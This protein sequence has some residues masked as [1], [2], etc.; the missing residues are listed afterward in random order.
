M[1]SCHSMC[2][3]G[4]WSL[5]CLNSTVYVS[6][7]AVISHW[8]LEGDPGGMLV[9]GTPLNCCIYI[10]ATSG[11]GDRAVE[12]ATAGRMKLNCL[13]AEGD[14]GGR[15]LLISTHRIC[16]K[17]H[18]HTHTCTS[19]TQRLTRTHMHT[20]G[21]WTLYHLDS[22][23]NTGAYKSE[24]LDTLP[25]HTHRLTLRHVRGHMC[26]NTLCTQILSCTHV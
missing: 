21:T 25:K 8:L 5:W 9:R 11:E 1:P 3:L 26:R 16:P 10:I 4:G 23:S 12:T 7:C 13:R 18:I 15:E 6:A 17:I 19:H 24:Y 22:C 20:A 14:L 2:S